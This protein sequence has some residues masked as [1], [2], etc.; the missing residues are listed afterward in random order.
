M[1]E[2]QIQHLEKTLDLQL[3]ERVIALVGACEVAKQVELCHLP[4]IFQPGVPLTQTGS[5][6]PQTMHTRVQL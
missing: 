5:L 6:K 3:G 2:I 1:V 4:R